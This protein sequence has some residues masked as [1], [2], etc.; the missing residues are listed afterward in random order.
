MA[1]KPIR[2]LQVVNKMD[3]AGIETML[4]NYYRNIDRN[5]VQFDFLTH[6]PNAGAYDEEIK[7]LGGKL[8]HAPRLYPQ[9]YIRY[10]AY[11]KSFFFAHPEYRI[12]HSHID[13]MSAFPLAAAKK[14][15]VPVRIA[16][17]HSTSIDKD[18]KLPIK[19]AAKSR[20]PVLA[21]DFFACSEEAARFLFGEKIYG[22][23]SFTLMKNAIP[24]RS[25]SFDAG[26]RNSVRKDFKLKDSFTV[27]HIGRFTYLKNQS[28][29]I[30]I[31][32][33]LCRLH[34]D[35]VLLLIGGGEDQAKIHHKVVRLGLEP[36]VHFLGVR[37]DVPDLLQA[38]DAFVLPSHYEGLPLVGIEAQAADLPCFFSDTISKEVQILNQCQFISLHCPA[39][40][41]ARKILALHQKGRCS[42]TQ[43]L[44]NAGFDVTLEAE[45]LQNYYLKK[46]WNIAN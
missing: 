12:V 36:K 24:V 13:A 31:F 35:S 30:D 1:K 5:E 7:A 6:R 33:E 11:M 38:M 39:K 37:G 43:E 26:K 21:T 9:N 2:I 41:W 40:D 18:Y 8:Y 32:N 17:S 45:K 44:S 23:Q 10:F 42:R 20:L 46:W 29:L 27:G 22:S 19:W 16:H 34:P 14:A 4:M 25:F 3:R 28:Y 15:Q